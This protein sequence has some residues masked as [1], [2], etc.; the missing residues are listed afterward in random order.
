MLGVGAGALKSK[1]GK[2]KRPKKLIEE[3]KPSPHGVRVV[4]RFDSIKKKAEGAKKSK[5]C[6]R[7]SVLM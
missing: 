3:V 4:P 2:S 5:V 6:V 7:C 1:P